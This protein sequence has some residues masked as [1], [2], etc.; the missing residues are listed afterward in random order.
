MGGLTM[1]LGYGAAEV[2]AFLIGFLFFGVGV[3]V[4][5]FAIRAALWPTPVDIK[6]VTATSVPSEDA[7]KPSAFSMLATGIPWWF[8]AIFGA[9]GL[10]FT[11]VTISSG[12]P[13]WVDIFPLLFVVM[14]SAL[15]YGSISASLT[16]H[17]IRAEGHA[18]IGTVSGVIEA[19]LEVNDAPQYH[20]VYRYRSVEGVEHQGYSRPMPKAEAD[21]WGIGDQIEVRYDPAMPDRSIAIDEA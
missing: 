5:F 21:R 9:A 20:V 3:A 6:A 17:R 11:M 19:N 13:L 4:T 12:A 15:A 16:A 18:T 2:L 10:G 7:T 1:V 8:G 14:G